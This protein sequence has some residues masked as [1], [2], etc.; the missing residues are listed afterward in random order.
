MKKQ[1]IAALGAVLLV[2]F[3]CRE[4]IDTNFLISNGQVGKLSRSSRVGELETIFAADSLVNSGSATSLGTGD[5]RI[6]IFEKGGKPLLL[7]TP[8]TDSLERIENVRV[9]DPRYTTAEGISLKSTFKDIRETYPIR[10]IITSLN[11]VVILPKGKDFYFT[12]SREELPA[13]LRYNKDVEI[14]EVQIPD[15]ARIK[16]LMVGWEH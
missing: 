5:T 4:T 10:K 1:R 2:C 3:Q 14:E 12:I 9:I 11:N 7:L 13:S 15:Q 16:Y 8:A 6:E